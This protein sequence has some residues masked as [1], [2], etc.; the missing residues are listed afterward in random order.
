M[1]KVSRDELRSVTVFHDLPDEQLDWFLEH[2][3]EVRLQPGEISTHAGDPADKMVVILEGELQARFEGASENVFT[4]KAGAVAGL[5]PYS[6]MTTFPATSRAV[7]PSRI[8]I[9]PSALFDDLLSHMPELGR[10]L[11][12]TMVDRTRETTRAEQQRDR[13]AALGKLSA[14]LAHELNNPAAAARRTAERLR[15]AVGEFRGSVGKLEGIQPTENE[16]AAIETLESTC[17]V[18][19]ETDVLKASELEDE[20]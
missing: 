13:L 20:I 15:S 9:F 7:R 8:L 14:G 4:V 12:A 18:S 5:L 2:A 6:R 10:R 3:T 16:R 17:C 11:V 1:P 19:P